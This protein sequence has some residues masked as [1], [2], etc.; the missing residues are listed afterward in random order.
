MCNLE[1]LAKRVDP[2][3]IFL[4]QELIMFKLGLEAKSTKS[5]EVSLFY[6]QVLID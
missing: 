2:Q 3:S 6:L 1:Q 5:I 4:T